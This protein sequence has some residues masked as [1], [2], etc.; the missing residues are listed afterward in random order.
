MK[1]PITARFIWHLFKLDVYVTYLRV[2][3][4]FFIPSNKSLPFIIVF[5][6]YMISIFSVY[7]LCLCCVLLYGLKIRYQQTLC[8]KKVGGG[9]SLHVNARDGTEYLNS[10]LV[11]QYSIK[12]FK[13][14]KIS[15][16]LWRSWAAWI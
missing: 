4:Y 8:V 2:T 1:Q 10:I 12:F 7:S 6:L 3:F 15:T 5:I 13:L 9:A 16:S 11:L 14:H